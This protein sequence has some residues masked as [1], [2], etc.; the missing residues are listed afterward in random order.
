MGRLLIA[1]LAAALGVV[2]YGMYAWSVYRYAR[3][4]AGLGVVTGGRLREVHGAV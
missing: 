4:G 2:P 1:E 3:R